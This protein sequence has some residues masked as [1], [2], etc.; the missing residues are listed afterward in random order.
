M[1]HYLLSGRGMLS[2]CTLGATLVGVNLWL[3]GCGTGG[4]AI[5]GGGAVVAGTRAAIS[6][7]VTAP[8]DVTRAAKERTRAELVPVADGAVTLINIDNGQTE[9]TTSTNSAGQYSFE[10]ARA[11]TNYEIKCTKEVDGGTMTLSAIVSTDSDPADGT[12][13]RP[14]DPDSTVAAEVAK[15]QVEAIKAADPNAI[16]HDLAGIAEEMELKRKE[17]QAPPPDLTKIE[18]VVA[19]GAKLKQEVTPNGSYIGTAVGG[20]ENIRLG[21]LIKDGKF[22]LL[23]LTD[24]PASTK[25][26]TKKARTRG[27]DP[28]DKGNENGN[29]S[30]NQGGGDRPQREDDGTSYAF[31]TV[32]LEGIVFAQT[33]DGTKLTGVFVGKVGKGIWVSPKGES[34]TWSLEKT[35]NELAGLYA[36]THSGTESGSERTN[37][38]AFAALLFNDGTF[39][40]AGD[41]AMSSGMHIVGTGTYDAT[42]A[43]T[44]SFNDSNDGGN[45]NFTA[46]AHIT[47]DD[48]SGTWS[49]SDGE[50]GTWSGTRREVRLAYLQ[51]LT[52]PNTP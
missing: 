42:G 44:I 6:G 26:A 40:L 38:G 28:N 9:G 48:L 32:T 3:V 39:V 7:T 21:A 22:F 45:G 10:T 41:D 18:S 1:R 47:G 4:S 15:D 20:K 29:G 8:A 13:T 23:G 25:S 49:S 30:E 51:S 12:E 2:A 31:G 43:L 5:T 35:T 27:E 50:S 16:I 11:D 37:T 46:N 33:K 24:K 19:A 14:L 17:I 52:P 36:G 34:G